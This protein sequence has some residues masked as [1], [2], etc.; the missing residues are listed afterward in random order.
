MRGKT[1]C[2]QILRYMKN[3]KKGITALKALEVCGCLRLS[4]RIWDLRHD[5]YDIKTDMIA[6]KGVDG[7]TKYVAQYSLVE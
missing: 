6:V 3:H 1:Q 4:G 7:E 5:G 2:D